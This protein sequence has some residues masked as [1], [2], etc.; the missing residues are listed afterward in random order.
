[1]AKKI[2]VDE[3]PLSRSVLSGAGH[4]K[5]VFPLAPDMKNGDSFSSSLS[6]G[7]SGRHIEDELL[8]DNATDVTATEQATP[9]DIVVSAPDQLILLA[10]TDVSLP[11]TPNTTPVT[12]VQKGIGLFGSKTSNYVVGSIGL[13]AVGTGVGLALSRDDTNDPVSAISDSNVA[14]N[15]VAE[16]AGNRTDVG[17]TTL[18]TDAGATISYSLSDNAGGRFVIDAI[19]GVITVADS[20]LLDYESVASHDVTV[21]ATST[22]GSTSS[23]QFTINLSNIN[24]NPVSA[25]SDSNAAADAVAENAATGT[26]VGITT[27]A[28]DA[29]AGATISYSLSDNAG[30]R[31]AID[32]SSGVITVADGSLLDFEFATRH[33]VTV[34]ATSSDGSTNS[35]LFTINL[36]NG[37]DNPVDSIRDSNVAADA[38]VENAANGTEVGITALT[39]DADAGTTISYSLSDNAGGR[40]AIDATSGVI[41]VA[42][43]TLLDTAI[44]LSHVVTVL[45]T[46]SDGSI[47]SQPF[48]VDVNAPVLAI[49]ASS[50]ANIL[51]TGELNLAGF[52]AD[53]R[54][55]IDARAFIANNDNVP[56]D[57]GA[58]GGS[59]ENP[60]V[61]LSEES[62]SFGP[63]ATTTSFTATVIN[64]PDIATGTLQGGIASDAEAMANNFQQV[65]FVTP[66]I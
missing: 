1:M 27:L 54:I 63:R 36:S 49:S 26:V 40:F 43:G 45:A 29:D 46:S 11:P 37:N 6:R 52:S 18:A 3:A 47:N 55:E 16:N 53:D 38:V 51:P 10:K 60:T 15:V 34:L 64:I 21:L 30:G 41:T 62:L 19:T 5:N 17:I 4:G 24:D 66:I 22:D 48:T 39:I 59:S 42:D 56:T 7:R 58:S 35:Q 25:I 61:Y 28:I 20:T 50:V 12:V 57:T 23:Q 44:A 32:A 65:V 33:D 13:A 14:A 8:D 9:A 31:F 2:V